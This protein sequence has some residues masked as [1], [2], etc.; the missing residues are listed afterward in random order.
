MRQPLRKIIWNSQDHKANDQQNKYSKPLSSQSFHPVSKSETWK[1][2]G[3]FMTLRNY[4][5]VLSR[6]DN[7]II[8]TIFFYSS[9]IL[10]MHVGILLMEKKSNKT[11]VNKCYHTQIS[12]AHPECKSSGSQSCGKYQPRGQG[13][14][15]PKKA[16]WPWVSPSALSS[17]L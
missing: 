13:G 5:W 10:E 11:H 16:E 4:C 1:P 8:V 7:L 6:Q 17:F 9:Y 15:C 2:T 14:I 3:C 12:T